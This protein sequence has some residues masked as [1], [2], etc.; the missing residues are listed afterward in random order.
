MSVPLRDPRVAGALA[1]AAISLFVA[2]GSL[3]RA[4]EVEPLPAA[5]PP[6]EADSAAA[7]AARLVYPAE[8]LAVAVAADPFRP[9]RTPAP[10]YILPGEAAAMA[11]AEAQAPPAELEPAPP[12]A[13]VLRLVGTMLAPGGRGVALLQESGTPAR[14]VRVGERMGTHTLMRVEPG[15]AVLRSADGETLELRVARPGS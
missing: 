8:Y 3:R 9:D 13:P 6:A 1:A 7:V 14:M 4:L 5:R 2:A 12:P 11:A 15:R 10:G